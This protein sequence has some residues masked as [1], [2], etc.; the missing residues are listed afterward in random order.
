MLKFDNAYVLNRL[1]VIGSLAGG[2]CRH[3]YSYLLA[4]FYSMKKSAKVLHYFVFLL[5][6]IGIL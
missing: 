4:Q 5:R 3:L 2:L 6:V 1:A